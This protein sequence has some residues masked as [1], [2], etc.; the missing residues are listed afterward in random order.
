MRF[1][2]DLSRWSLRRKL[3]SIIMLSCT[4]CLMVSLSVM[5]VSS[6]FG[7]YRR[8]LHELS[9]LADVLAENGQAALAFSDQPEAH[10][11]V[12]SIKDHPEIISAWMVTSD[13][14][15]LASWHRLDAALEIPGNYQ[16]PFRKLRTDFWSRRA[17]L[18]TPV[19]KNTELIGYVLLQADFTSLLTHQLTNLGMSLGAAG[20]ALIMVYWLVL[21]LQRII[22]QPIEA[23]AKTAR[24]ISFDQNYSLR[25]PQLSW[26]EI[27]DLVQAFNGMLDEIQLRDK[28]LI[29]HRDRLEEEVAQRTAQLQLAKDE[30]ESAALSKGM[31]LANMSHEIRTPMNAIIGLSDLALNSNPPT[32][33]QD[34]L[35]KIHTSS[36]ALLGIT[37]DILDYS[38]I[39]AG[40]MELQVEPFKLEEVLENVINLFMVRAEEK[41][42]EVVLELD[43]AAPSYLSGDALRLSQVL[44]NLVGNAVKFTQQG[45]IHIKIT[46]LAHDADSST[47]K[48]SVTDTGIGM[49]DE[50]VANLFQAFTQA[51]G[52]ITR[53]F[54]GTGLGLTISQRLVDMMGG[55]LSVQS[56]LEGG[57]LFEF[58][59]KLSVPPQRSA[60]ML[61]NHLRSMRVLVVDDLSLSRQMLRELLQAWGCLVEEAAT[62]TEALIVLKEANDNGRD[63]ELVLLDWKM[64]GLD[65]IQVTKAIKDMVSR[66]E[67]RQ[68]PVVIMVT[69]FSRDDLLN[70]ATHA[71]P[72][73]ILLKPVMP[74]MLLD[75]LTR[76]Q[77]GTVYPIAEEVHPQLA[78]IVAMAAPIRGA[79]ILLVEDNEINQIVANEYLQSA[80]LMVTVVKNGIEAV[81]AVR[82]AKFDAVLMDLQMP[83]M[84]GIEATR[85]IRQDGR[86]ADL[87]IIAMTA[88][89]QAQDRDA[90]Y[91]AGM[92]DHVSKPVLPQALMQVLLR[93]IKPELPELTRKP[94]TATASLSGHLVQ[95]LPG[96][97]PDYIRLAIGSDD[98]LR[99]VLKSFS[100]TFSESPQQLNQLLNDGDL[101]QAARWLHHLKGAAG[102]IGAIELSQAANCL[103]ESL[104]RGV[105][106]DDDR[107]ILLTR[108]IDTLQ[109]IAL[110]IA[111][112]DDINHGCEACNWPMASQLVCQLQSLLDGSDYVPGDLMDSLRQALPDHTVQHLL[113]QIEKQVGK[114]DYQR[115]QAT[116]SDLETIIKGHLL[117]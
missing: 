109:T 13:G 46:Q 82:R 95:D 24:N 65:G 72:D 61:F 33:L 51:D 47:L 28:N 8:G 15:V 105:S 21:R 103:E 23:L 29:S 81:D 25:V 107:A 11:L 115:A 108:L 90:C 98:K 83:E 1:L 50:Q 76:L 78:A 86:F 5:V 56:Q 4:V 111:P 59:L 37:N 89:V 85:L 45:E 22:S 113:Q 43:P 52:S 18:F 53:R 57:S 91:A 64:P 93:C 3:V 7:D 106:I 17:E 38:K 12:A 74:S 92:N 54:G 77:G 97:D 66:A 49:T 34:Y 62:G 110:F 71:A 73:D 79:R 58:T 116:L 100:D 99:H 9:G 14:M 75:A 60:S 41:D 112:A 2:P 35:H 87:P 117:R 94:A 40:H 44:S 70:E 36:L 96:F 67:I 6:A 88:A 69:A 19:I 42:L 84:G 68:A 20:L 104:K 16:F 27:G 63:F 39:E 55:E 114:I 32:K 26:D 80:G 102:T 30:A 101:D 31:F 10:R 48:F